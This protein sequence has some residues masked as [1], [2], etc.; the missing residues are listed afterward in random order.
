[1]IFK[2]K[3]KNTHKLLKIFFLF[4]IQKSD[5]RGIEQLME[6]QRKSSTEQIFFITVLEML[7]VYTLFFLNSWKLR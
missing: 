3:I 6:K 5:Y 4:L 7:V 2:N 1:M